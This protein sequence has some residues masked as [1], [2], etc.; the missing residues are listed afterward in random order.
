MNTPFRIG[1]VGVGQRGLQ[2]LKALSEL[3]KEEILQIKALADPFKENL[4]PEKIKNYAPDYLPH[5]VNN[6]SSANEMI[7]SCNLD[8][9]WFV[10]PPNQHSGEIE[11]AA[12]KEIAIFAEKPQSLFLDEVLKQADVIKKHNTTSTVGFQMRYDRGYTDIREYLL[13][14]K[15]VAAVTMISE[16]AVE[17]HGVKHT[18]TEKQGGP[19]NRIWTANKAWSGTSI[20]EAGI[21]QTDI[22]RYWT[23]DDVNWVSAHY[24][25][26]PMNLHNT[27]GDNP[28][29]YTVTYGLKKGGICNLLFTK[30]AKSY[31]MGRFDNIIW[32]HGTIKLEKDYVDYTYNFDNWP[33]VTNPTQEET[34]K[35]ISKG[36]HNVAMGQESTKAI[37]KAFVTS[38]IEDKPDLRRNSFES[39]I[40]SIAAVLAANTSNSLGGE[41]IYIDKFITGPKYS[42]YRKR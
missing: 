38:I 8:A 13:K 11:K 23:D 1:L 22:M 4:N 26:R 28:I 42:K 33:P 31:Y 16:G 34:R 19:S 21:H 40:N 20:V 14:N 24:T 41:K 37:S 7:E 29:A 6:Y 18:H 17:G 2:H 27:E 30:P 10:I 32:T 3:Q 15:W 9:I 36:P 25:E 39:S 12:E 5:N 35:V